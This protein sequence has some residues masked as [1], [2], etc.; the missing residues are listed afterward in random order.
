MIEDAQ[1]VCIESGS[2]DETLSLASNN[3]LLV[4]CPTKTRCMND[5]LTSFSDFLYCQQQPCI[6]DTSSMSFLLEQLILSIYEIYSQLLF[7]I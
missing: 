6:G 4:T 2:I 3:C 1:K 7:S 5:I